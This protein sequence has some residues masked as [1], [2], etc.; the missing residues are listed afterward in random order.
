MIILTNCLTDKADEGCLKVANSLIKRIRNQKP[1][2]LLVTYGDSPKQGDLHVKTNKLMLNPKLLSLLRKQKEPVLY[3]PAVAKA[4]TMAARVFLLSLFA[5]KGMQVIQVMCYPMG[6]L[7]KLLLKLSK[8]KILAFSEDTWQCFHSFIGEQAAYLKTGVDTRRFSPIPKEEKRTLREKYGLPTE[9]TIVL[10]VG[11]LKAKRNVEMLLAAN[12]NAH[13]VLVT[14]T[15]AEELKDQQLK[16]KLLASKNFSL[17]EDYLPNIEEI[18]QLADVYLFP[19]VAYHNCIDVPL[20]A[21]EAAAC[22]IPVVTT[23]YGEMKQLLGKP[24]F[25]EIDSF[26]PEKLSKL[27]ETAASEGADPRQS[28]LEYDWNLAVSKVLL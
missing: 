17:I 14:S 23:P 18:Y 24:G 5:P 26:E 7:V 4:H 9:K 20:S 19:V 3:I 13:A 28:V 2:T 15:Y 27:V 12:Q 21:L 1:E 22:G 16:Q 25:Y 8:A 11:H 10:H 6:K